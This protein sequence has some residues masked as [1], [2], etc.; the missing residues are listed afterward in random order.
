MWRICFKEA[1]LTEGGKTIYHRVFYPH[2]PK[3]IEPIYLN[4]QTKLKSLNLYNNRIKKIK[5]FATLF[6]YGKY[7]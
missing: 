1:N 4:P 7:Y 3:F 6:G 2:K 5:I